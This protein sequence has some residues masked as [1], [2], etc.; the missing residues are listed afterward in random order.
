MTNSNEC[1]Y[2]LLNRIY[3]C[4]KE[5][6]NFI[7]NNV[8]DIKYIKNVLKNAYNNINDFSIIKK[9]FKNEKNII[10]KNK[11]EIENIILEA[12]YKLTLIDFIIFCD[13]RKIP[14]IFF[15][16]K[17][18]KGKMEYSFFKTENM[19]NKK[20]TPEST[21]FYIRMIKY[22]KETYFA[23]LY[24][25]YDMLQLQNKRFMNQGK[26]SDNMFEKKNKIFLKMKD[27]IINLRTILSQNNEE[28]SFTPLNI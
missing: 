8:Y 24:H 11:E 20:D 4:Y 7:K 12:N 10:L 19:T 3:T 28:D 27:T 9:K 15:T 16:K 22:N 18:V 23:L 2:L 21:Y 1:N 25:R 5:S 26:L 13:N 17:R 6:N 14:S